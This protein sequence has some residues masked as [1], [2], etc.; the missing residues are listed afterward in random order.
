MA[1]YS[2]YRQIEMVYLL[3][4]AS[5]KMICWPFTL[6]SVFSFQPAASGP[7]L[8]LVVEFGG[9]RLLLAGN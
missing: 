9:G 1:I 3:P 7:R 4:L 8:S 6:E 5:H 2:N